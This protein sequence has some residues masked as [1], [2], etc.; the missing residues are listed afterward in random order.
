MSFDVCF[1]F[2]EIFAL[3]AYTMYLPT[4]YIAGKTVSCTV[5]FI[6]VKNEYLFN[7]ILYITDDRSFTTNSTILH[8]PLT[9]ISHTPW[10]ISARV[11]VYPIIIILTEKKN[12]TWFGDWVLSRYSSCLRSQESQKDS[13]C[14]LLLSDNIIW[15]LQ[16]SKSQRKKPLQ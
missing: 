13:W 12:Q 1:V 6:H 2:A 11:Y 5:N 4:T 16:W 8:R 3:C 14:A 10:N 15:E 7:T 9:Q